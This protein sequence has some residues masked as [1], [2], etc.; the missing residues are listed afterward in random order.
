MNRVRNGTIALVIAITLTLVTIPT[1][2]TR[3]LFLSTSG[4]TQP[5]SV[6]TIQTTIESSGVNN[7]NLY[8]SIAGPDGV[9]VAS[10]QYNDV[11]ALPPGEQFSYAWQVS[12]AGF[13]TQGS[14]T[15]S[16]C[17]SPGKS[18]NCLYGSASTVSH[19]ANT[20]GVLLIP[21]I[22]LLAWWALRKPAV[23]SE[24]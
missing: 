7:T 17:W 9:V 2:A 21:L 16:V 8:F 20:L 19:F 11:P 14:Y 6:I 23:R 15:V 1:Q 5:D 4:G 10:H 3:I 24:A 12:N 13:P 18:T 22:L